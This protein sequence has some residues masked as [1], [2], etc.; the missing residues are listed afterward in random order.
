MNLKYWNIY[1]LTFSYFLI[2]VLD[3]TKDEAYELMKDCVREIQK[4]LV[5]NLPNF[6]VNHFNT[7][8]TFCSSRIIKY[9][10]IIKNEIIDYRT[11]FS[12]Q[13]RIVDKNGVSN[14]PDI[15]VK[16]LEKSG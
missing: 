2:F 5:I 16:N 8:Y 12:F 15:S 6:E 10:D 14:M 7:N 4:R 9:R 1:A 13:V 3:L 11:I